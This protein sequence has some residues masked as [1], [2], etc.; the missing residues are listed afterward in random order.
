MDV[1]TKEKLGRYCLR[2]IF[3]YMPFNIVALL[4]VT[5]AFPYIGNGPIWNLQ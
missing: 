1:F 2:K 4:F 3:R 5:K